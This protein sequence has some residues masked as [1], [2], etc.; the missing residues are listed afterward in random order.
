MKGCKMENTNS[1][2]PTALQLLQVELHADSYRIDL[3]LFDRGQKLSAELLR[4]SLAGIAIVGFFLTKILANFPAHLASNTLKL[5]LA[6]AVLACVLS[7]LFSLLQ[8]FFAS[9]AM[10][11]HIKAIKLTQLKDQALNDALK[12]TLSA[13]EAKFKTAHWL[14]IASAIFLVIAACL[15]GT[16]FIEWM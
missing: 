15:L 14:L 11:H 7:T 4:L 8:A 2:E 12:E 13:R 9:G 16:D 10:F 3:E 6:G 5:C 1:A